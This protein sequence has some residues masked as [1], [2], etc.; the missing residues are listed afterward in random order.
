MRKK[1]ENKN[2]KF[3][4]KGKSGYEW[5][6]KPATKEELDKARKKAKQIMKK[7]IQK[8]AW[9]SCWQCNGAHARFLDGEWGDW[10][11]NC[12]ECGKFYY[13]KIDITDYGELSQLEKKK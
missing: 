9:R 11:L 12:F 1:I 13:D 3:E 6:S 5:K 10:V 8:V 4:L 2:H 7:D